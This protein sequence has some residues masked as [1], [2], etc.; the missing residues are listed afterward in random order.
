MLKILIPVEGRSNSLHAVRHAIDDFRKNAALE[1]HILN[2]QAPLSNYIAR[3]VS[4]EY[5]DA[6]RRDQA[7]L[8]LLPGKQMLDR[9]AVPYQAHVK[10]GQKA[11][12]IADLARRLGCNHI[13]M[14]TSR[15]NSLI[16]MIENSTTNQVIELTTVP[17]KI[18]AGDAASKLERYGVPAGVG[19]ALASL[20]L[21]AG[22]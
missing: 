15:K 8:A 21:A 4:R 10:L 14:S 12:V 2:V 18:I 1:I 13:V 19:A 3:F 20:F 22:N 5:R 6:Y 9:F 17:V 11:S 7:E 16:R